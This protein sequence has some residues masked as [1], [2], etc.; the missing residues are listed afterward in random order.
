MKT[1]KENEYECPLSSENA[2]LSYI[3]SRL[4]HA[5]VSLNL[6]A[7]QCHSKSGTVPTNT[8]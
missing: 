8:P 1:M 2:P 7:L 4:N 5:V 3:Q 6:F